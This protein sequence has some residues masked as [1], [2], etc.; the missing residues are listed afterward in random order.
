[1]RRREFITQYGERSLV[2]LCEARLG[3]IGV[4]E[5]LAAHRQQPH[6]ASANRRVGAP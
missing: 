1:M 5:W 2:P 4:D 3:R 6:R